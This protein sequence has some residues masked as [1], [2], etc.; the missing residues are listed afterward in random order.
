MKKVAEKII[1]IEDLN[2]RV[3]PNK[4]LLSL[5]L[6][7][8]SVKIAAIKGQTIPIGNYYTNLIESAKKGLM[9]GEA[10]PSQKTLD[11]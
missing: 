2:T 9:A 3:E 11:S 7:I 8:Q 6:M 4:Y 10:T 5:K 1:T